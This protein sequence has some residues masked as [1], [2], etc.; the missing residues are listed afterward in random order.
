IT[1]CRLL[2]DSPRRT[3]ADVRQ[4]PGKGFERGNPPCHFS[5]KE[6]ERLIPQRHA[7]HQLRY[8]GNTGYQGHFSVH[9]MLEQLAGRARRNHKLGTVAYGLAKLLRVQ[10]CTRTYPNLWKGL[11][12]LTDGL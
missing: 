8:R 12:H 1:L 7:L 4:R 9:A 5:R 10:H 11:A 6:F 2:S 3:E